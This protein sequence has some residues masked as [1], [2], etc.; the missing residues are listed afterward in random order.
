MV[1][2]KNAN[3]NLVNKIELFEDLSADQKLTLTSILSPLYVKK[4]EFLFE[5]GDPIHNIYFV[6]KGRVKIINKISPDKSCLKRILYPG[7]YYGE[8][9]ALN[10][11]AYS[12][13]L[14]YAVVMDKETEV[15][16]LP[17]GELKALFERNQELHT[18]VINTV[19]SN[20]KKLNDRLESVMLKKSKERII[21]FLREM[22][23]DV[24]KAVGYEMLIKHNLTHQ[25]IA[26]Y[27][28]I[29]RQKVTTILNELKHEGVI[30]LE[31]NSIL[32]RDDK[33]L[34]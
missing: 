7:D 21:D 33:L 27:T 28:G 15:L 24:G 23:I 17:I 32:V 5:L 26:D 2:D 9:S 13:Y 22:S 34:N 30:H 4:K 6:A 25:E 18:K 12:H 16:A 8:H 29:S 10:G 19:L 1:N 31:R 14:D 20:F 11:E 3:L